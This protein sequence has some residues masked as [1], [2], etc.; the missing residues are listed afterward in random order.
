EG[1]ANRGFGAPL[2]RLRSNFAAPGEDARSAQARR[3]NGHRTAMPSGGFYR[4]AA[5]RIACGVCRVTL[6]ADGAYYTTDRE[7]VCLVCHRPWVAWSP[8]PPLRWLRSVGVAV[9]YLLAAA[10]G[11][12]LAAVAF[13]AL[14]AFLR[15]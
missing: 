4:T 14:F 3:A 10:F 6:A 9:A 8:P 15:V 1:T 12:A 2:S 11:F 7:L 5:A 13:T